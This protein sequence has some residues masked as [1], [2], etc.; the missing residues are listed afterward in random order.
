VEAGALVRKF[1][2]E[3]ECVAVV[4]GDA[5]TILAIVDAVAPRTVQLHRDESVETVAA[6]KAAV[7]G[8]IAVVRAIRIPV[9]DTSPVNHWIGL[10]R[11][12]LDAGADRVLLDSKTASMPAGTGRAVDWSVAA[13]VVAGL[14]GPVV[15]AGG[16]TPENVAGAVAQVRPWGVDVISGIESA[17]HRKVPERVRSF[18]AAARSV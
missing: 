2:A 15:L 9:G 17:E 12:F 13:A 14:E 10:A 16:L 4:G 7:G 6:V 11:T 5:A 18:V 1:G 8:D 3:V